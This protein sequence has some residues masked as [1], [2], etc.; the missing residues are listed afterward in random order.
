M[1]SHLP[2]L[3][4]AMDHY[5]VHHYGRD[6]MCP[7]RNDFKELAMAFFLNLQVIPFH[8]GTKKVQQML[9]HDKNSQETGRG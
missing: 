3:L 4:V 9:V 7:V 1:T 6:I 5:E 2:S 8:Q